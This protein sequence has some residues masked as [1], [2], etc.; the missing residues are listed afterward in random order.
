MARIDQRGRSKNKEQHVRLTFGM[1]ESHG[2]KALPPLSI[3]LYIQVAH[4]YNGSNNGNI[5][6]STREAAAILRVSK[7]TAGKLFDELVYKG[8]LKLAQDSNFSFKTR[9]ARRWELTQWPIRQGIAPS[10]DWRFWKGDIHP[11]GNGA[12]SSAVSAGKHFDGEE[13]KCSG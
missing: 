13:V 11:Q 4:R 12:L 7:T 3:A 10:N 6:F 9:T 8:F 1:I 5:S 2:Y